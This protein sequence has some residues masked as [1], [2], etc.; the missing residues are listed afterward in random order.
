MLVIAAAIFAS[1]LAAPQRA[2]AETGATLV[3][4]VTAE[5]NSSL[6]RRVRA[7]L[8]ALGLDVMVLKPPDE[9][10]PSRAPLER[11]ARSVG[12]VAAV[13][14]I[15]S[16]EGKV[17]VWVADRVT[18]K[19]VVRELDASKS[20]ASEAAIAVGSVELLRA[21]LMEL[22][23]PEPPHG[24][25]PANDK[26]VSLALPTP[27]AP[28]VPRLGLAAGAGA[29]LGVR[30]LG[31]SANVNLGLWVR[32]TSHWGARF[33]G[34]ASLSPAHVLVSSGAVDVQSQLFGAM[35]SYAFTDPSSA[36]T[37]SLSGGI[38]AAHVST[39]GVAIQPF[40]SASDAAWAA[41]PL[42]G[43]GVAWSFAPALHL[44]GDGLAALTTSA[45]RVRTPTA[46]VG[47]WG[48]P[49]LLVSLDIEVLWGP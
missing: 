4:I 21:S 43:L 7:E 23:S 44:R 13:R 18:G 30:G 32:I 45:L 20:G 26:V 29:E 34:H 46:D 39:T 22:H 33:V 27:S 47:W 24:D 36:W 8:Q 17:E 10:S 42:L 15:A 9:D 1:I 31:P 5:P 14:V 40:V 38:A 48:A 2:R 12:A 35:A 28:S 16:S 11:A 41:A 19:A 3:A 6:T 25:A 49:A 37:P